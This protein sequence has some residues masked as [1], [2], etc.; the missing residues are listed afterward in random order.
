MYNIDVHQ[1]NKIILLKHK[2]NSMMPTH[3]R[4]SQQVPNY[5]P[6]IGKMTKNNAIYWVNLKFCQ[7]L[8][9]IF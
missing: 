4:K 5:L 9:I 6:K 3:L 7:F 8:N 2:K 1:I